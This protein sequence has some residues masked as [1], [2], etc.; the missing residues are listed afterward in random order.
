MSTLMIMILIVMITILISKGRT[1]TVAMGLVA[2]LLSA[3]GGP[4][5]TDEA[6]EVVATTSIWGDVVSQILG[7]DGTV[8]VLVPVGT[9]THDY[10]ASPREVESLLEADLVVANGLGLE[11]SLGTIL[12]A[13]E[14]DGAAILEL[15][16]ELDPLPL[17]G[18]EADERE[19]EHEGLDPHVWLDPLRAAAAAELIAERLTEIE[20]AIDWGARADDYAAQLVA[21]D[22]QIEKM[23]STIA[24]AD[25]KLVTNHEALGYF[26]ARYG[27]VVVGV[28]IPGG[29]TLAEPSSADIADL[30]GEIE[31]QGVDA[32]FAESTSPSRLAEA[33]AAEAGHQVE[34]IELFTESLGEPGS[35]AETLVDMLLTDA[36]RIVAGLG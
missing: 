1:R 33:V 35:G 24:E 17:V 19:H 6:I 2:L 31:R 10:E 7:D 3:C 29:S 26:A 28:I 11:E 22:G 13:A 16:P 32:V 5:T 18:D 30:V 8:E 12:E 34:V 15:A 4:G 9:D 25:R 14:A 27:L 21:A 36:E 23:V 20:P